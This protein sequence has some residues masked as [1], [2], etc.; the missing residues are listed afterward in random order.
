MNDDQSTP[1]A[2]TDESAHR[3]MVPFD[4]TIVLSVSLTHNRQRGA[5]DVNV[6]D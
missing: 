2:I 5:G 4:A 6:C 1:L 3:Q